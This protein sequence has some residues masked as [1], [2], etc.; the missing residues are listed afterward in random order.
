MYIWMTKFIYIS[1]NS[2]YYNDY[3]N[4]QKQNSGLASWE[5]MLVRTHYLLGSSI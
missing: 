4:K 3:E 5:V 1:Y 2:Q